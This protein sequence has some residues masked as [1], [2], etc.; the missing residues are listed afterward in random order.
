MINK[1]LKE[2]VGKCA[3]VALSAFV[4][5]EGAA[6]A[7]SGDIDNIKVRYGYGEEPTSTLTK[8]VSRRNGLV[9]LTKDVNS[10]WITAKMREGKEKK[11]G[12]VSGVVT[13]QEG[14]KAEFTNNGLKNNQYTLY[15]SRTYKGN[16]PVS[17]V[18]GYWK[19]DV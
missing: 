6:F 11:G 5:T 12:E 15:I 9:N 2:L 10:R 7:K 8:D 14:K 18:N 1:K 3:I 17:Y 19:A 4:L 16:D 13:L